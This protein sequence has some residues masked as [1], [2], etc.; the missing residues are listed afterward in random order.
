MGQQHPR[1]TQPATTRTIMKLDPRNDGR[2]LS[3]TGNRPVTAVATPGRESS[4]SRR[5]YRVEMGC[6]SLRNTPDCHNIHQRCR[7]VLGRWIAASGSCRKVAGGRGRRHRRCVQRRGRSPVRWSTWRGWRGPVGRRCGSP[8]RW[9]VA[10]SAVPTRQRIPPAL[11]VP[12]IAFPPAADTWPDSDIVS[13]WHVPHRHGPAASPHGT[14][15]ARGG[16]SPGGL[17]RRR[18]RG[19]A[20]RCRR[21]SG[22]GPVIADRGSV[23]GAGAGPRVR[24][25]RRRDRIPRCARSSVRDR[26]RPN[27]CR[28]TTCSP[29]P[30]S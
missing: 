10:G 3:T 20:A 25:R 13:V 26:P 16:W 18:V 1:R 15:R 17:R 22:S 19:R 12:R 29:A 8:H 2:P 6:N 23:R 14:G 24:R 4:N 9:V 27:A 7:F 21:W 5:R 30:V 28:S 11:A